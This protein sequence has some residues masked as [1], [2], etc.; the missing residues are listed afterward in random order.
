MCRR[1]CIN[2]TLTFNKDAFN[3]TRLTFR[4]AEFEIPN[5]HTLSSVDSIFYTL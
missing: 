5:V 3:K 4:K 1:F 2:L